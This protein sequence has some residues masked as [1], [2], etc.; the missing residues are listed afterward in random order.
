MPIAD[1]SREAGRSVS[2]LLYWF[3]EDEC[4]GEGTIMFDLRDFTLYDFFWNAAI[5]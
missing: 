1:E 5:T 3:A 2:I 4:K